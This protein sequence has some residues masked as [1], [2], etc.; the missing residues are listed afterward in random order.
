MVP[1]GTDKVSDILPS[2]MIMHPFEISLLSLN[3]VTQV[4]IDA[5]QNGQPILMPRIK[6]LA[7]N[8]QESSTVSKFLAEVL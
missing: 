4:F 8:L 5:S 6:Y 1:M 7:P 2:C 3:E